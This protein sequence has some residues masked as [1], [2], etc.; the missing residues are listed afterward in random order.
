MT[1]QTHRFKRL[2]PFS[3]LLVLILI[4]FGLSPE[5]LNAQSHIAQMAPRVI[6]SSSGPYS[7]LA[8]EPISPPLPLVTHQASG[9]GTGLTIIP[10][11]NANID[12]ATQAVINNAVTFYRNTFTTNIT[13]NIEFHDMNT[14]FGQSTF[15][16]FP[17][18]YST[19]CTA[20]VASA[21]SPDDRTAIVNTPCGSTNPINSNANIGVKSANGR[22]LG[23]DTPDESFNFMNSPCPTFT[24][25]G[26]IGLNVTAIN[27]CCFLFPAVE[28]E[29]DEV[30]GLSSALN[31]TTT[32]AMPFTEDVFRWQS[33]GVRSYSANA[34]TTNP[35]GVS[36][37]AAF[38]S[39]DGGKTDL[40]DFNNC[41]NGLDYGDW[42]THTPSQVQDGLSNGTA[43]PSLNV[44][45][46]EVRALD[47]IGY[48][49]EVPKH[50]RGQLT[51]Q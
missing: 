25:S 50:R 6:S 20:L 43:A 15:F 33:S 18:P 11:F 8:L 34:S 30:L 4:H 31:G 37:P 16:V 21:T 24:G 7:T 2:F 40:D 47:V 38:F 46:P 5:S 35:C 41:D 19:Y 14:G 39:I 22:A 29:I 45:S 44:H 23:I 32:P 27:Q 1:A 26:C 48:D 42:I 9:S 49:I 3:I 10:T 17:V 13:V 12:P 36:T 51:S 28:H